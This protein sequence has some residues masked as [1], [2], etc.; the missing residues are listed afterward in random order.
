MG[1]VAERVPMGAG[2]RVV[3]SDVN[4][5]FVVVLV[6]FDEHDSALRSRRFHAHDGN[7]GFKTESRNANGNA[8]ARI[9][10]GAK[11]GNQES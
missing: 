11:D 10:V 2:E 7:V 6:F 9:G 5:F 3:A 1:V 8:H 4:N